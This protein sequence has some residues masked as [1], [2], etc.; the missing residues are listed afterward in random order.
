MATSH[1]LTTPPSL[2]PQLPPQLIASLAS[3]GAQPACSPSHHRPPRVPRAGALQLHL[4]RGHACDPCV[5]PCKTSVR[6]AWKG[7][8]AGKVSAAKERAG[9]G[10]CEPEERRQPESAQLQPF[11]RGRFPPHSAG[12][13]TSAWPRRKKRRREHKEEWGARRSRAGAALSFKAAE[14]SRGSG[15]RR[16]ESGLCLRAVSGSTMSPFTWPRSVWAGALHGCSLLSC[17]AVEA[18]TLQQE[19]LQAIAEKRKRQT[20]IENKRRQLEDDRRQLQHLKSKALRERWLL[21]GAPSS[22][23]EEDEA[24]KKQMQEDEVKT[25]ELEET[26]QRLE[27]ELESLENSSSATSTKENLA[28][29]AA[30]M[31]DEKAENV[32]SV[33]KS[34]LGTAVAE[35]KVSGS[36]MKAVQGTDMMKAAMYSVEI[37]VEKDRVTGETKVLSSTTLLPQNHCVQGI[38]V[39]EDELKVVHAVSAEDGALQNEAQPLSSSE[40]DELL[41]KADEVT[42]GEATAGGEAPGSAASSQKATPRRE[43]TGLQAK[44]REN[45]T[46]G[47]EPSREQP[48][49]MIFMGYQNVE[50][51]NETKKVLGLEGTIK[52]ELV[53]I[54]DA[55]SKPE[56]AGKDHAPPNGTALE[57]AAAPLQGDEV[58]GGEKPG[59]NAAETKEAEPDMD[60]KKQRCK[61]CTVM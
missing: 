60:A 6:T 13:V 9:N 31:K 5:C 20:E 57:P 46:E 32:P 23:S 25:K 30:P 8:C 39:Y 54:E 56:P 61:C 58:P 29:V 50:D 1:R 18:S 15:G 10:K 34:P 4:V 22:A 59:T 21:E 7:H 47:A 17:R 38:K 14:G 48:V 53:V 11:C 51:E 44:P 55:E 16:E 42:L 12:L 33:Q 26:I 19:R 41:H 49:T 52:A 27:R 43:I 2:L 40:V 36:P 35:K 28:E 37:T 3:P 24:M 45:S